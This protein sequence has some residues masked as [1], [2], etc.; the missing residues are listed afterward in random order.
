MKKIF[1]LLFVFV[2]FFSFSQQNQL[3]KANSILDSRR[4]VYIKFKALDHEVQSFSQIMSVDSYDGKTVYA[5]ANKKEFDQFLQANKDFEIVE[6]YY[7]SSKALTMASTV[8]EMANWDKYPVYE[9]FMEMMESFAADYPEICSLELIGLSTDGRKLLA[10]KLSDNVNENEAEPEFL[11]TGMMHGDELIGG[12]LLLRLIDHILQNYGTD[13]QITKL[14]NN[15]QIYI[16]PFANPDGTYYGGNNSVANS[17]RNNAQ[18]IDLNRNYLDF[19]AGIHPDGGDYGTETVLFMNYASSRNFVMSANTHSGAELINYP[20]D[21]NPTLPADNDWW[22]MVSREYANNAQI[23]SPSGYLTEQDNGITNGYAWYSITG[24]RQDYMNYYHHCR[25]VTL[26][27]SITKKI[28]SNDL[29]AYWNYNK[30][31][32][33]DYMDQLS[34]GLRGFVTDSTTGEPLEAKVYI[35]GYDFFNSHVFSFPEYGD[36]YRLLKAGNYSVTFSASGYKSKTID[37][38]ISDYQQTV[39][40]VQLVN[41]SELPPSANFQSNV[42]EAECNPRIQFINTSEA[43]E[44]TSYLW[45]F[46]DGTSSTDFEPNHLYGQNG[47][48]TIKLNAENEYGQNSLIKEQYISVNLNALNNIPAFVI[49]ETSGSVEANLGLDGTFYWFNNANDQVPFS[50]G[51]SWT[52]P[53]INENTSYFVQQIYAGTVLNGGEPNNSKGGSY[54][55]GDNYLIFNCTQ[56]CVLKSV[57]VYADGSGIRTIYLRNSLGDV[58]YSEDFDIAD[59][60]QTVNLNFNLPVDNGLKLGCSASLGLYRG[61]TGIFSSF[62]YPF[63]LG[64]AISITAS[65]VVWWNDGNRYYAYFYDWQIKM[66]DCYSEKS[67][68]NIY[69]NQNPDAGFE[70]EMT[71]GAVDFTNTSTAA[72]S[73]LWDFGDES[74]STQMN[75]EHTYSESGNYIVSLTS[76]SSCGS[77]VFSLEITVNTTTNISSIADLK[78]YPNPT[79]A[80]IVIENEKELKEVVISDMSGKIIYINNCLGLNK[81]IIDIS[82]FQSGIYF[83]KIID[84]ENNIK[85]TKL[86]KN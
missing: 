36:Y 57:K 86:T 25:E 44:S 16:N 34:Y 66:P 26:E 55:T 17:R 68:L 23:N 1:V 13:D 65:N 27:L 43:S 32:L 81:E 83:V 71:N 60:L 9:V 70:F 63:V 2:S 15:T 8:A 40:D 12:M 3:S 75:P 82:S 64:S 39:L 42:Q 41:L 67:P 47:E 37:V 29:P 5:Y 14:V 73:F 76:S 33:L 53:E 56:E 52:T 24:S 7:N 84:F 35:D 74:T 4:E 20:Y 77:D 28:D 22:V 78:V 58:L 21:T 48:Y 62:N 80:S 69:V 19:M 31:A 6:D 11:Y 46:G 45:D 79:K 51:T 49:C 18:N 10:V 38:H 85:V 30:K 72:E 61:S 59:G 54:V 50:T